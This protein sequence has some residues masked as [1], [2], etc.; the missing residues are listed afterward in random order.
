MLKFSKVNKYNF[1]EYRFKGSRSKY[2]KEG[3]NYTLKIILDNN[4][5]HDHYLYYLLY[6]KKVDKQFKSK[7][8]PTGG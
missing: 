2:E 8:N 6:I 4:C 7:D 1:I 3:N 5:V